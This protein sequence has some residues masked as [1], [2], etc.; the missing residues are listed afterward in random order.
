VKAG[1][2]YT[3][4]VHRK[5]DEEL[6]LPTNT[7]LADIGE[8]A[9]ADEGSTKFVGVFAGRLHDAPRFNPDEVAALMLLPIATLDQ[10]IISSP[11]M[12]TE[13]FLHVYPEYRKHVGSIRQGP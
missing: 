7:P 5:L 6:G 9:M 13:T 2:S 1:E 10:L 4:A 12:F 3:S 11:S 8:V